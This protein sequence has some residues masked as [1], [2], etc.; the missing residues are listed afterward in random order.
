MANLFT[1]IRNGLRTGEPNWVIPGLI[2]LSA[3]IFVILNEP[4]EDGVAVNGQVTNCFYG[5]Q[6]LTGTQ[7]VNCTVKLDDGTVQST[8][9]LGYLSP[10]TH[11]TFRRYKRRLMG[12]YYEAI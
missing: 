2:F 3:T 6:R 9:A 11:V 1:N 12:T 7:F 5:E 4:G 8:H 10:G